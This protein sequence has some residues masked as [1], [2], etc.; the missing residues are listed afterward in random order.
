MND[1]LKIA[2]YFA[3]KIAKETQ[4]VYHIKN[5]NFKGKYIY[6]LAELQDINPKL[7][8]K[9]VA[10]YKRRENHPET[11]INLL[12]CQWKDCINL[13]T[14]NPE[15]ILQMQELLGLHTDSIEIFKIKISELED[16]KFCL[17]DEAKSP[18]NQEAY[19]KVSIASY[20]ETKF[21]PSKTAKYLATC[22]E[23]RESPLLFAYVGHILCKGSIDISKTEVFKF[24]A[25]TTIKF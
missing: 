2:D 3:H 21:V 15:K 18:K 1:V 24:E 6:P 12:D 8:K 20:K 14:I 23:K 9:E 5:S 17:Y 11:K 13:S 22:E 10:K 4:Y 19:S 16:M 25:N 7:Y